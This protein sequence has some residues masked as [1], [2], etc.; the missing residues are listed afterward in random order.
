MTS[1]SIGSYAHRKVSAAGLG[2]VELCAQTTT[3]AKYIQ[4]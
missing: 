4:T 1:I 2:G 3:L